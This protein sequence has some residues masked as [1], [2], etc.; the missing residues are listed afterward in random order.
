M[1][2]SGNILNVIEKK[3]CTG[4]GTCIGLCPSNALQSAVD[5]KQG[6]YIPSLIGKSCSNCSLCLNACPGIGLD[7][8][9]MNRH[10]FKKLPKDVLFGNF[11]NNYIGYS[12]DKNIRYNSSS[13][14]IATSILLYALDEGIIDGA[15]VTKMDEKDPLRPL[16]FIART[17]AEI[18]NA[19]GSKY[20]PV[21]AN[22]ALREIINSN[23][24]E[25]FAVVGLP[26][27]IQGIQKACKLNSKLDKK[28]V[29]LLG[30][31]CSKVI[32][33]LGH[34]FLFE[35]IGIDANAIQK[36]H[37]RG[38][39]WPGKMRIQANKINNCLDLKDYYKYFSFFEPWRCTLC[40][41]PAATLSD[42]SL[43][44][45]WIPEIKER[46]N[47]GTS[48]VVSRSRFGEEILNKM[49]AENKIELITTTHQEIRRS[50]NYFINRI[51]NLRAR[52]YINYLCGNELPIGY[53]DTKNRPEYSDIAANLLFYLMNWL[54]FNQRTW[55]MLKIYHKIRK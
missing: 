54:A 49:M 28:I 47:I 7:M 52:Y 5:P 32:S 29:L 8:T 25:R 4:C 40:F 13:G 43:G 44:D 20:C 48:I 38:E 50:Q 1:K 24:G 30:L 3:L 10:I 12:L 21:P 18:I 42:I 6:I 11:I 19:S 51:K 23:E 22:V 45:A 31:F 15:L 33:F 39:G 34:E 14:G 37:Y 36:I 46:D 2:E 53:Y 16:P 26:C 41:D 9:N 27:H 35:G 17:K 55:F